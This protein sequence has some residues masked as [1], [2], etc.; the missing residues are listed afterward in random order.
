MEILP[1]DLAC[2]KKSADTMRELKKAGQIL[3]LRD[4]LIGASCM[5]SNVPLLAL[6]TRHFN[7]LEN[8]G[9]RLAKG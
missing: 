3:D 5:A 2:A 1:F 8:F 7:R 6:N 4:L 9:L